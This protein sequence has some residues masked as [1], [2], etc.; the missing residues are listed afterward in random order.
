MLIPCEQMDSVFRMLEPVAGK[1]SEKVK[2]PG[3]LARMGIGS[4]KSDWF[5]TYRVRG[6]NAPYRGLEANVHFRNFSYRPR[7]LMSFS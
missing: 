4:Q 6:H 1:I 7:H 5:R 3:A 2:N